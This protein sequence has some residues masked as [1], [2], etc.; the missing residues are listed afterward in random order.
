[1]EI[2]DQKP[3]RY[4]HTSFTMEHGDFAVYCTILCVQCKTSVL[5][6]SAYSP[7]K[8]TNSTANIWYTDASAKQGVE[9]GNAKR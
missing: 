2:Q 1:M 3:S 8:W 7:P 9:L 5:V 4:V 6:D